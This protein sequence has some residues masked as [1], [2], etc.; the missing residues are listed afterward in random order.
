MCV[1]EG[2]EQIWS[3]KCWRRDSLAGTDLYREQSIS[4]KD[5]GMY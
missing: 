2:M 4:G 3:R 5:D 1:T